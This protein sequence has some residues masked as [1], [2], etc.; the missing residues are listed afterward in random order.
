M[1][2]AILVVALAGAVVACG[3]GSTTTTAPGGATTAP[4][5][6]A[7]GGLA[8]GGPV[9]DIAKLCD[10]LGPGDFEAVG[11]TGTGTPTVNSDGPGSA[12][13]LYTGATGANGGVEFDVFFGE[14]AQETYAT[15]L[16]EI[17]SVAPLELPGVDE[18][19][20]GDGIAGEPDQPASIVVRKGDLVFTIAAPGGPNNSVMLETLAALV[21]AR[22]GGLGG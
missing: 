21:L 4:G 18:A 15:I 3:G 8:T 11:I 7:T 19:A 22:A 5:T 10:L 13:C 2:R 20:G 12:S 17:S 16:G 6:A 9:T 14:G 1:L